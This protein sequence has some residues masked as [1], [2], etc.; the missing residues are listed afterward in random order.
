[1]PEDSVKTCDQGV[2]GDD[3]FASPHLDVALVG[4]PPNPSGCDRLPGDGLEVEPRQAVGAAVQRRLV[5]D[6]R[7]YQAGG[8]P[9]M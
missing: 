3:A 1:M 9:G 2:L 4:V 6:L 7:R 5:V 8:S